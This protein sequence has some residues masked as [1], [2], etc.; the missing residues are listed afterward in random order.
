MKTIRAF[1]KRTRKDQYRAY[2]VAANGKVVWMT[3]DTYQRKASAFAAIE[4]SMAAVKAGKLTYTYSI[5]LP[6]VALLLFICGCTTASAPRLHSETWTTNKT[7]DVTHS[8]QDT[9]GM[10][11]I[12]WGDAKQFVEKLRISNGKTQ[13]IGVSGLDQETHASET[14]GGAGELL[15]AGVAGYQK[16]MGLAPPVSGKVCERDEAER[17]IEARKKALGT[18]HVHR[19]E[20]KHF[21][22]EAK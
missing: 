14:M 6:M 20:V 1:V 18:N 7:G 17:S 11:F 16:A 9:K 19:A 21:K 8:I 5:V 3:P 15:G 12:N 10:S 2:I 4:K 13:G 22:K